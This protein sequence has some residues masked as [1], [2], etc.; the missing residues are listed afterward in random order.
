MCRLER[1]P[2]VVWSDTLGINVSSGATH[3]TGDFYDT[4]CESNKG[5]LSGIEGVPYRA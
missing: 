3:A 2:C 1:H 5:S 4:V